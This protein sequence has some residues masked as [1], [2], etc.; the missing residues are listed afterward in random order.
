MWNRTTELDIRRAF[1]AFQPMTILEEARH[2][3]V[4]VEHDPML[5]EDAAEMVE[6]ISN[7]QNAVSDESHKSACS[8]LRGST[9]GSSKID[10]ISLKLANTAV[11]N[12]TGGQRP[13]RY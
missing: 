11:Q 10:S 5:Y 7:A 3:F 1:T 6:Y 8:G 2:T 9:R 12:E 13:G 4:I